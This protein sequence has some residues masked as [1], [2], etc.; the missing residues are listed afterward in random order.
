MF[1]KKLKKKLWGENESSPQEK[2][3]QTKLDNT[4][5]KKQIDS[6]RQKMEELLKDPANAKKAAQII[7]QYLKGN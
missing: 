4:L 1:A 7:E 5:D 2:A 6:L 3:T